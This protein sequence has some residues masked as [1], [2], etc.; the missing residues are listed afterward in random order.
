MGVDPLTASQEELDH[1]LEALHLQ[2]RLE[3]REV[4]RLKAKKNPITGRVTC[5]DLRAEIE[6]L[7]ALPMEFDDKG[8][9]VD[10]TINISDSE[11]E[12]EEETFWQFTN[13]PDCCP[14][15]RH[16]QIPVPSAPWSMR[17]HSRTSTQDDTG[18]IGNGRYPKRKSPTRGKD[19]D[20]TKNTI[21]TH[22][23]HEDRNTALCLNCETRDRLRLI[24][25]QLM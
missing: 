1:V 12:M 13:D 6:E 5:T 15:N 25:K 19:F 17:L 4:E 9:L 24:Q 20:F 3:C 16:V 18:S 11:D 14:H 7:L 23:G 10:D 21:L 22:H 8:L 2:Y